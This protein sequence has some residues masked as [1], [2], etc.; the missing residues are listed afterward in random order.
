MI[1]KKIL[2]KIPFTFKIF[3]MYI[4]FIIMLVFIFLSKIEIEEKIKSFGYVKN[5]IKSNTS[6]SSYNGIVNKIIKKEGD[7][8]KINENI[9][10]LDIFD[11]NLVERENE[12]TILNK[13]IEIEKNSNLKEKYNNELEILKS[14]TNKRYIKSTENGILSNLHIKENQI[15]KKN[16]KLYDL[17]NQKEEDL[18][19]I[20]SYFPVYKIDNIFLEDEVNITFRN[21]SGDL[22][23]YIGQ[24]FKIEDTYHSRE[25]MDQITFGNYSESSYKVSIRILNKPSYTKEGL[26]VDVK[27]IKS[28][29][30]VLEWLIKN[31]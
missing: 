8:I 7:S 12:I 9:L 21:F 22:S 20:E 4:V 18:Y 23:T 19:Y 14:V 10:I 29:I 13:K 16:N 26:L 3:P 24:V 25:K 17:K 1:T 6:Y 2:P 27:I 30:P 31:I 15:I 11:D 28:K 5:Y